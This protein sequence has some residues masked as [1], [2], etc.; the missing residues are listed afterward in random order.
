MA[1][2]A[3]VSGGSPAAAEDQPDS[4][5]SVFYRDL[6]VDYWQSGGAGIKESA[7]RALLG[8][9]EDVRKF[10]DE[11]PN[12]Q[13]DD[14]YVDASRIFNVGGVAVREA[15]KRA[16]KGTPEELREYLR[17]G[18]KAPLEEDREVEASRVINFGGTGVKDAGKAALK[19]GPEAV[20][21]FLESGQYEAQE[22][23][24]EVEVS[25]LINFGGPNMKAAGKVALKGTADDIAEFL[26]VGQF[27]ARDRD[28]EHATIAQLT[29]QAKQ[30]GVQAEAATKKAEE[31]SARAVAASNLAK[32]AAAKAARETEEA[33]KDANRAAYKAQQAAASARAAAAAAQQAIGAANAANRAART[34]A[35]AAAQTANAAAA[36]ANAANDAYNAAIAAAGDASKAGAA[37]QAA[38]VARNAA[39][40]TR[41]SGAAAEQARKASA[42]A[43]DAA[44]A[45]R[46]AGDNANAAADSAEEANRHAEAAGVHSAEARNAAA[47]A[48]RHAGAANRAADNATALARRSAQQASDARDAA[49]SAAEHA[50]KAADAADLAAK[51]AG[52]SAT[53]AA[54]ARK[55]ADAAK[56]A[57]DTATAALDTAKKVHQVALDVET[58]DLASR[59]GAALEQARSEKDR[60]DRLISASATLARD[61]RAL[62]ATAE[63]LAVEAA[64]AD[65]DVPA[66]AVKGRK[67]ALDALKLRGPWQ[68]QAAAAALGGSDAEV[69]EFLRSG[70][71]KAALEETRDK[72]LQLSVSSPHPSIRQG[73][74]EALKGTPEQIADF[75]TTGQYVVGETDLAVAVSKVNNFGGISVKDASKAALKNGTGK[76]LAAF[77]E[78]GQYGARV[79]D[80]EVIASKLVN[81]GG[82]EVKAAAKAALAGPPDKLHEF[83]TV[84]QYMAAR[85][86][87]LTAHH[88]AQVERLLAE[89]QIIAAN[90]QANRWRAAEAAAKANQASGEA[91]NAADEAKK[92]AKAAEGYKADARKSAD[93]ATASADQAS[94]SAATARN[95]AAAADRDA[96]AAETSATQAEF[97]ATYARQSASEADYAATRARNSAIAAGKSKAE[98]EAAASQAWTEVKRKREAEIAELKRQAEE[99]QKQQAEAAKNKK[100][101]C[102]VPYNRDTVPPCMMAQDEYEI[103]FAKPDAELAKLLGKAAWEI[104]GGADIERCIKEPAWGGCTM[105]VVGVLPIGKLK[106]LD[107]VAD[108]VEGIAKGTRFGKEAASCLAKQVKH[109]FPAGTPV[110][111]GDRTTRPIEEIKTGDQ[112]LATNPETGDTGPHRVE[113]TIYTPDDRNFTDITLDQTNGGGSLTTTDHHPFWTENDKKWKN[114]ADLTPRDTLRTPDGSTAQISSI[115]HWTGLTPAY[116]LTI[117]DLHTYYV[118][119]GA[120]PVLVHNTSCP[121]TFADLGNNEFLSPAGLVYGVDRKHGHKIDHILAHT[122]PDP[123]RATHTVFNEVNPNKVLDLVDEAWTI[124]GRAVRYPNDPFKFVI[125]MPKVIGTMGE[126]YMQMAVDPTTNRILSAYPVLKP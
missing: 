119:A 87:G 108:G 48:R 32:E 98:A 2:I 35:L 72:V 36:A 107:K 13:H 109:S 114:A 23:D 124:R 90:A 4:E 71:R 19:A 29:E 24:N 91:A 8:S 20:A 113:A 75:Y 3:G 6:V 99:A 41:A 49:N 92:S 42:A 83:V 97:S 26:E 69:L 25:K 50:E 63:A 120:T 94:Q 56:D 45:S 5:I 76:A 59:S 125:P 39:V 123:G 38:V 93:A 60:S 52:Q 53:A 34:A 7:E 55:W 79:T 28:Q 40:L 111:M 57:A 14:D 78:V 12:I 74:T 27:V 61:A 67:L 96:N 106:L 86:D 101:R 30:A 118:L 73:A 77:L 17:S 88:R 126:K 65:V 18:W 100:K 46:S 1:L 15:T 112:V 51:Y 82:D 9:D 104:S 89:G 80:E 95:A 21:K 84:G 31:A 43:G 85:K 70:W 105:A 37:K 54:D 11:A 115:R 10:L 22:T 47:E 58:E 121:A 68:Q 81:D 102:I 116:N 62:D 103:V 44:A 122:V 110:L 66:T 117:N 64:K 33:R 16:L